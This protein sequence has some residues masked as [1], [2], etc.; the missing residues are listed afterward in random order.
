MIFSPRDAFTDHAVATIRAHAKTGKPFFHYI[1][2]T[3][4][5]YPLHA[6]PEDIAKYKGRFSEGWEVLRKKRYDRQV[7][8]GLIDPKV[9]PDPGPNPN[10]KT[11]PEG[12]NDDSEWENLR[13]EVYAA[14]VDCMDQNIGRVLQDAG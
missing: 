13:M 6:K 7:E 1:P 4:P 8:M 14:M 3:A 2:Y 12:K 11:W 5:H 9:Y 10:N